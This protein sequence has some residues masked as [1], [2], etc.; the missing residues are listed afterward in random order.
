MSKPEN[1]QNERKSDSDPWIKIEQRANLEKKSE[2]PALDFV[3]YSNIIG[4][5]KISFFFDIQAHMNITYVESGNFHLN[6][7]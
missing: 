3:T 1:R 5:L 2:R 4:R 6:I 7:C